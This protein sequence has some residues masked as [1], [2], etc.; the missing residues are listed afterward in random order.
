MLVVQRTNSAADWLPGGMR[1]GDHGTC[2]CVML[3]FVKTDFIK[4][5]S[6][7]FFFSKK[8]QSNASEI[9]RLLDGLPCLEH[10]YGSTGV[11]AIMSGCQIRTPLVFK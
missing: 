4:L 11:A 8:S 3:F 10:V 7:F 9:S 2:A 6:N 5:V 1:E